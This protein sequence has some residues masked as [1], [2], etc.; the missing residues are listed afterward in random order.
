[1]TLIVILV[2][3]GVQY[4]LNVTVALDPKVCEAMWF[5]LVSVG[6]S[7]GAGGLFLGRLLGLYRKLRSAP[8]AELAT[9]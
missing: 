1:M 8:H 7:G 3:F 4:T 2:M 5:I 9:P 6:C